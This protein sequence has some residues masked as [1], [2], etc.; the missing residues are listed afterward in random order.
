MAR[1]R[2][3]TSRFKRHDAKAFTSLASDY[4]VSLYTNYVHLVFETSL[5]II[6][7]L[8]FKIYQHKKKTTL[9]M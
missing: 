6:R 4:I 8:I 3:V 1:R 5:E 7:R 2:A 9:H